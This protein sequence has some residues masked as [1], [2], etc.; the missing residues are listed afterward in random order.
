MSL[1]PAA[2]ARSQHGEEHSLEVLPQHGQVCLRD[3]EVIR[4]LSRGD[5]IE[6]AGALLLAARCGPLL[7]SLL[8]DRP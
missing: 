1:A 5:A 8:R 6:L 3:E 4:L 2:L 7:Q